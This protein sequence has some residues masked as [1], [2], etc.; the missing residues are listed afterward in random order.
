QW[1]CTLNLPHLWI[2]T[3]IYILMLN[4][5]CV[6]VCNVAGKHFGQRELIFVNHMKDWRDAQSYCRQNHTDLVSVRNQDENQQVQKIMNDSHISEAWIGLFRDSWQWSDQ[7]NSSFRYWKS[8]EPNNYGRG[9]DC[10][11]VEPNA[12]G[13]CSEILQTESCGSGLGSFRRDSA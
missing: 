4:L 1:Q 8:G 3:R 5:V 10:T 11:A 13:Q 9:E 12:Q 7:S 6:T 2:G